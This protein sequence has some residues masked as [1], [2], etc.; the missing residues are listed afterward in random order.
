M[1]M[2]MLYSTIVIFTFTISTAHLFCSFRHKIYFFSETKKLDEDHF[3]IC[4][5]CPTGI[6]AAWCRLHRGLI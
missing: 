2:L 4:Y 6:R 5:L 3:E 1:G